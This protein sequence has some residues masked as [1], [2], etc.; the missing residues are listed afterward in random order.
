MDLKFA[1]R[2]IR[3]SP[4]FTLLSVLI[5]A[6]GIGANT[7]IFSVVQ[8]VV[9]RRLSYPNPEQ[10]VSISSSWK[11]DTHFGLV[12]GPDFLDWQTQASA[13][14]YM[15]VHGDDIVSVLANRKSEFTG[16]A[17]ISQNFLKVFNVRPVAGRPLADS[18]FN[19]KPTVALV[20]EGFWQRHFG[21]VPFA[22]GR[23]LQGFG[24]QLE[25][26]G[27]LPT[28]FHFPETDQTNVW[29]PIFDVLKDTS[30]SAHNYKVVARLK[31]GASV[32]EAQVQLTAVASR[33]ARAY[34]DS[35]QNKG[36]YVTSLTNF[37]VRQVKTSLYILL[38]AVA[39]V[40]MIAC[41]NIA[42]L[43][44]ARG[45]GRMRELAIRAAIGASRTRIIRQ[46]FTETLLLAGIGTGLGILLAY[47]ILPPLLALAPTF[48]PRLNDIRIDWTVLLFCTAAGL[49]SSLLFGLAPALQASRVDP[50]RDLR[51]GGSRGVVGGST[52][53][54]RRVFITIEI[55]LC[56][57]LL[58]SAG[59]LLR[60]FSALTK[61]DLGFD[62]ANLLVAQISVPTGDKFTAT[63]RVFTPL[64]DRLSSD[65]EIQSAAIA[66]TLP[67]AD[68]RSSVSYAVSGQS[69]ALNV[70]GPQAGVSVVSGS[71][72]DA[73]RT[74]LIDG[75]TFSSRDDASV[76][77]VVIINRALVRHSF[78]GLNP[79]G[80]KILCGF[81]QAVSNKWMTVIGIVNDARLDS[82]R[83][84]PMPELYLPYLQHPSQDINVLVKTR[85][86]PLDA[87]QPVREML[88]SVDPE[89]TLKLTTMES[90]LASVVATPR[91]S[92]VLVSTFA[93][94]AVLLAAIGIYGVITYSV[95]Q[96]TSEIG[97]RMALGAG[98]DNVIAM[99]L[100]EALKLTGVGFMIGLL[101]AFAAARMLK[102]QLFE[103]SPLDPALY[104]T[105]LALLILIALAAAWLPAWRA[106]RVEPLEALRQE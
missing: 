76:Q 80:R 34:P 58:I 20:S 65:P 16:A 95:S 56:L 41:A 99:V 13:F 36:A 79:I 40:L 17:A 84:P 77:P 81:D 100:R 37:T 33:L 11:N 54:L 52:G 4:G 31:P 59:L 102:S 3:R 49:F 44:L 91:F 105:M 29:V 45:T 26:V 15:A 106:S 85:T 30:R 69:T 96:R 57:T 2:S 21:N 67:D 70:N 101:G 61:V 53:H 27:I 19:G 47:A 73:V 68:F 28:G 43:L 9:F 1:L 62:P 14:Q 23:L 32:A 18:D 75:R 71:Y 89:A 60:T 39:L 92:S 83:E 93:G 66:R 94:L 38:I 25:I 104:C 97:V 74:R 78:A 98:R 7:A 5:L 42:N 48:V 55:A 64:L 90:H 82:P 6:L 8:G 87:A 72:F 24:V 63:R 46:L 51:G 88:S 86:N 10:L 12:S 103:I 22:H 50:N 35:N